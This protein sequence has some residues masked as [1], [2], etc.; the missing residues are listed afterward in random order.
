MG[1]V[2]RAQWAQYS[3]C[4]LSGYSVNIL[5]TSLLH[6][7]PTVKEETS[8]LLRISYAKPV[9]PMQSLSPWSPVSSK[10]NCILSWALISKIEIISNSANAWGPLTSWYSARQS[11][12]AEWFKKAG[13]WLRWAVRK[14]SLLFGTCKQALGNSVPMKLLTPLFTLALIS[15][16]LLMLMPLQTQVAARTWFL[17]MPEAVAQALVL[18]RPLRALES[19]VLL[20]SNAVMHL[21]TR[22]CD[23]VPP[24]NR[25]GKYFQVCVRPSDSYC[26]SPVSS[27]VF[28]P[29]SEPI[30]LTPLTLNLRSKW[31]RQ[32]ICYTGDASLTT[33]TRTFLPWKPNIYIKC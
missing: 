1:N 32:K 27:S 4:S 15:M 19:P 14:F 28:P 11:F 26:D 29:P 5:I 30:A 22:F 18:L 10:H 9:F 20:G 8:A 25:E 17:Q 6:L 12:L 7:W 23:T 3:E 2:T 13:I 21:K 31:K 24:A 33:A 16:E